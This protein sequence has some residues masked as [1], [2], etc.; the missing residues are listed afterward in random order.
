MGYMIEGGGSKTLSKAK[1]WLY[2]HP[3][4]SHQLLQLLTEVIIEYLV[5]QIEHGAQI[6]QVFDS[7]AE[8]LN[9]H[10]YTKFCLPYL[11]K[12]ATGIREGVKGLKI[13]QVP[14]VSFVRYL[15]KKFYLFLLRSTLWM[16]NTFFFNKK[17]IKNQ[18]L[19]EL[20]INGP[21][22]RKRIIISN[23]KIF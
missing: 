19:N 21:N 10:L 15:F 16:A 22:M 23:H 14:L 6:V 4:L 20:I 9:K 3:E 18:L 11:K 2:Q 5:M 1:K 12:I 17:L 7:S 13:E 8:Y